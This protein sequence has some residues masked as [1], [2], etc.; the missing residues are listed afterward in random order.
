MM[1]DSKSFSP[2]IKCL[3]LKETLPLH[4]DGYQITD[5]I[6]LIEVS[7]QK[8]NLLSFEDLYGS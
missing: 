7:V 5:I 8:G 6:G 4:V 3:S 1:R 2:G